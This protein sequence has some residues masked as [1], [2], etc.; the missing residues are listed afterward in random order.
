VL[1]ASQVLGET[2][3]P[4]LAETVAWD[5]RRRSFVKSPA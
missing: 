1:I 4:A 3:G 5:E 2:L